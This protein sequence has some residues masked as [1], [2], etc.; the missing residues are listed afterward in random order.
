LSHFV[1]DADFDQTQD[2]VIDAARQPG[3]LMAG[4][5]KRNKHDKTEAL[6]LA[7]KETT[8][9]HTTET[10]STHVKRLPVCP[11]TKGK[12]L[13]WKTKRGDEHAVVKVVGGRKSKP[14]DHVVHVN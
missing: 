14:T 9:L 7:Q 8:H 6:G 3:N 4:H 1:T 5:R 12:D 13:T 2:K 10:S 11:G